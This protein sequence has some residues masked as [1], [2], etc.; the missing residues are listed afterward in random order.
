MVLVYCASQYQMSKPGPPTLNPRKRFELSD[1][2]A[3]KVFL[4]NPGKMVA[5][6]FRA[7]NAP[8]RIITDIGKIMLLPPSM[9]DEIRNDNRLSFSKFVNHV[10]EILMMKT[11]KALQVL[12]EAS[13]QIGF[14]QFPGFE[15]FREGGRDSH[16]VQAVI[17]KDLTKYLSRSFVPRC[18]KGLPVLRGQ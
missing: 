9:A 16:I 1:E 3:K 10:C 13:Y 8:V 14:A 5:G 12:T 11:R 2:R 6:W 7:N 4:E 17:T 18:L 15:S